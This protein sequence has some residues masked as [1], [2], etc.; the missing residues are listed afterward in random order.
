MRFVG[1]VSPFHEDSIGFLPV[2]SFRWTGARRVSLDVEGV[3]VRRGQWIA[4][5]RVAARAILRP[6]SSHV[7]YAGCFGARHRGTIALVVFVF[8]RY[9]HDAPEAPSS[10]RILSRDG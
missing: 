10:G 8:V 4:L 9:A 6:G 1:K 5:G 7:V 3:I 2:D